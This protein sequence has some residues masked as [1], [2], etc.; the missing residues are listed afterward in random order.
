M[1]LTNSGSPFFGLFRAMKYKHR[2]VFWSSITALGTYCFQTLGKTSPRPSKFESHALTI[3]QRERFFSFDK[4][5]T[6]I[7]RFFRHTS[8]SLLTL[9]A[10]ISVTSMKDIGLIPDVNELNAFVAAAGYAVSAVYQGL[11]DPPFIHDRWATAQ[12]TVSDLVIVYSNLL[13]FMFLCT[14]SH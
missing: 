8:C 9:P 10:A 7:V 13:L 5:N 3:E 4:L 1:D 6:L 2:V 11:P 14:A 12:F